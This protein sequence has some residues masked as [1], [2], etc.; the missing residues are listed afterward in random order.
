MIFVVLIGLIILYLFSFSKIRKEKFGRPVVLSLR[1]IIMVAAPALIALLIA[2]SY[3]I[4]PA[5]YWTTKVIFWLL[6]FSCMAAYGLCNRKYLTTIER[7]VYKLVFFFPLLFLL[8]VCIPLVG[9]GCGILFYFKFIGDSEFII[10]DDNNIRIEQPS[11]RFMGSDPQPVLYVK[12]GLTS[13][14][15]TTLPFYYDGAKDKIEV[16]K[17]EAYSYTFIFR[18]PDNWQVPD[19]ADTSSYELKNY[20]RE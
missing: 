19:G 20:H 4:Y 11:V 18:S 1:V 5:Q 9:T 2:E 13:L 10:Y 16:V 15:D 14:R 8:F 6:I 17:Q 12:N 7:S 3:N